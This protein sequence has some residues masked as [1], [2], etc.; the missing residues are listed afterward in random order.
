MISPINKAISSPSPRKRKRFAGVWDGSNHS[1]GDVFESNDIH[2]TK[3]ARA[4]HG[5]GLGEARS[6]KENLSVS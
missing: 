5:V 3:R 6:C 4:S 2:I 1:F